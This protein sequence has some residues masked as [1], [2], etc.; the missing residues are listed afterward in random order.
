MQRVAFIG[1][2]PLLSP[3]FEDTAFVH[4][5]AQETVGLTVDIAESYDVSAGG[6]HTV[7]AIGEIAYTKI[8]STELIGRIEFASNQ[9]IMDIDGA[10]ASRQQQLAFNM[11]AKID[12]TCTGT[13]KTA[14]DN[15][16]KNCAIYAN[17]AATAAVNGSATKYVKLTS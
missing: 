16:L 9:L 14:L 10:E 13:R 2:N 4:I 12:S 7:A 17:A 11:R 15:A 3:D 1:I 6:I 5:D 8:G